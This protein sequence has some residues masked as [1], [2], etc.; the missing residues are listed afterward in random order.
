LREWLAARRFDP[1]RV[2]YVGNDTNDL[3]CMAGV[4]CPVAV[5]DAYPAVK[6]AAKI[7]LA[8]PGGHGAV[9]ELLELVEGRVSANPQL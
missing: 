4:G 2:V 8:A 1:A 6:A 9:R 3:E 5:A 7:V